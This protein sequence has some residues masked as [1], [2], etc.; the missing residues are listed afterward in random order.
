MNGTTFPSHPDAGGY[1]EGEESSGGYEKKQ[2]Q[3]GGNKW[4][5]GGGYQKSQWSSGGGNWQKN[6]GNFGKGGGFQR[7][8][9]PEETDPNQYIA[10]AVAANK[11][12][13]PEI[14]QQFVELA[15]WLEAK[16]FTVRVDGDKDGVSQA[17]E[18]ATNR[19]EVILPWKGFNNKESE[20]CWSNEASQHIAKKHSPVYDSIP[21]G[22]KK[23]LHR[24]ARLI[25]G[26]KMRSP[27]SFL[28]TW[29]DDGCETLQE[30][31]SRTGFVSHQIS[32]TLG[33]VRPV[34]NLKKPDAVQRLKQYVE[35]HIVSA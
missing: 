9:K 5:G 30:K 31:T 35:S 1:D 23:F 6:K 16:G 29:S 10:Y 8:P 11:N 15:K 18:D 2:W 17:V 14:I 24:N 27:V 4:G 34:F 21:D 22:V 26:D 32:I 7:K 28:I 20:F 13:P 25:M 3:G 33:A 19:K 12:T